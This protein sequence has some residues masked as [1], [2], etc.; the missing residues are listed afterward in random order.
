MK[1]Q[2]KKCKWRYPFWKLPSFPCN[3]LF[4][5]YL[6]MFLQ[7]C[8]FQWILSNVIIAKKVERIKGYKWKKSN[9]YTQSKV[10]VCNK[11][12]IPTPM[13]CHVDMGILDE[14]AWSKYHRNQVI[15]LNDCIKRTV[16]YNFSFGGCDWFYDV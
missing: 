16:G 4:S 6:L 15:S 13:S 5:S 14:I 8:T 10:G 12:L 2:L 7:K 9:S 3:S 1:N 11:D